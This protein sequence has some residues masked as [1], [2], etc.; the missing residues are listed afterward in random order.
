MV[1]FLIV[2][3]GETN[4]NKAR[5]MMGQSDTP[6]NTSGFK[7]A[8]RLG[9]YLKSEHKIHHIYTSDLKRATQTTNMISKHLDMPQDK[10]TYIPELRE[11]NSGK[12]FIGRPYHEFDTYFRDGPKGEFNIHKKADD[13][14]SAI[15]FYQRVKKGIEKIFQ[16]S[17]KLSN[18][19]TVLLVSHGGTIRLLLGYLFLERNLNK[20]NLYNYFP[21]D[22]MNCSI[23]SVGYNN[24]SG[25]DGS[26]TT[27]TVSLRYANF[28][29]YQ[30]FIHLE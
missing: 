7:Q 21:T 29:Q 17:N 6:L 10:I 18:D 28:F 15:E 14:E 4:S 23:T 2:R 26:A 20:T 22:I 25:L 27:K 9:K 19:H 24:S 16:V 1:T 5:I 12:Q 3:H 11:R 8:Q 30:D 13:G